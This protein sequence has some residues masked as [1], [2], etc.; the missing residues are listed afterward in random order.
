MVRR[1]ERQT[2][3]S[4]SYIFDC[5][6]KFREWDTHTESVTGQFVTPFGR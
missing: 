1:A 2:K 6:G 3:K 4:A 5:T